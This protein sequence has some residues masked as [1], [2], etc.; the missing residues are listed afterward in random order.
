MIRAVKG[1]KVMF[2]VEHKLI[3]SADQIRNYIKYV[4]GE[5][6]VPNL[7]RIHDEEY[8]VLCQNKHVNLS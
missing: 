4:Q 6:L 2:L 1:N 5:L 3:V 7:K 8:E